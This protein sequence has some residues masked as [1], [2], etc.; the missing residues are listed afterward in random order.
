[1][2]RITFKADDIVHECDEDDWLYDVCTDAGSSVPFQCKAGACG[3]CAT[4][5]LE[6]REA[7]GKPTAREIRTLKATGVDPETHRLPCMCTAGGDAVLGAPA[8]AADTQQELQTHDLVVE[9]YRP[10]NHAVCE[11]RFRVEDD[12]A[13]THRPG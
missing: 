5:V 2:P 12:T 11:V 1:M 6:G 9:S 3:T 10:L 7:L 4:E 13:F 8:A